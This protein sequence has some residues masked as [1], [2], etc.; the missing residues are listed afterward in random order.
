MKKVQFLQAL[1]ILLMLLMASAATENLAT[2]LH[3]S[4]SAGKIITYDSSSSSGSTVSKGDADGEIGELERELQE[5]H[6]DYIYSE[7]P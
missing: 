7:H 5:E 1:S 4:N 3:A 6:V 2:T